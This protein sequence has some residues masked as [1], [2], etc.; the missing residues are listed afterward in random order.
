MTKYARL[1]S[2]SKYSHLTANKWYEI[3]EKDNMYWISADDGT[4]IS[5]SNTRITTRWFGAWVFAEGTEIPYDVDDN[6]IPVTICPNGTGLRVGSPA[7]CGHCKHFIKKENFIVTCGYPVEEHN[8]DRASEAIKKNFRESSF[9]GD[10]V[11]EYATGNYGANIMRRC[12]RDLEQEL[13]DRDDGLQD[14]AEHIDYLFDRVKARGRELKAKDEEIELITSDRNGIL[15]IMKSQRDS[16]REKDKLKANQDHNDDCS[17]DRV[18]SLELEIEELTECVKNLKLDISYKYK[19]VADLNAE[20]E[21]ISK[22]RHEWLIE[23]YKEITRCHTVINK[24]EDHIAVMQGVIDVKDKEIKTKHLWASAKDIEITMLLG[25]I[26]KGDKEVA[27]LKD[28]LS[29]IKQVL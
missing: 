22:D 1:P 12:L 21:I 7:Y 28:K 8:K 11:E 20:N 24:Q 16:I 23:K 18:K 14:L 4:H 19:E 27:E 25:Q 5:I 15:A 29:K 9:I 17:A 10:K 6:G 2:R 3:Y 13:E 26:D